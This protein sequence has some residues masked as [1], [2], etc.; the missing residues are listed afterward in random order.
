VTVPMSGPPKSI[1]QRFVAFLRSIKWWFTGGLLDARL[2]D[3]ESTE[4]SEA[5]AAVDKVVYETDIAPDCVSA[6]VMRGGHCVLVKT[7]DEWE[8]FIHNSY[9]EAADKAIEWLNLQGEYVETAKTS[10]LNRRARRE[11]NATRKK[12]RGGRAGETRH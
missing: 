4:Y 1:W 7:D 8:A 6:M 9:E 10:K 3:S 5:Q 12:R 11:F 2:A